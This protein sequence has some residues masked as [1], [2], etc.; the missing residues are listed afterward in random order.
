MGFFNR[1]LQEVSDRILYGFGSQEA[2]GRLMLAAATDEVRTQWGRYAGRNGIRR[3]TV[4]QFLEFAEF[5]YGFELS[6]DDEHRIFGSNI[7]VKTV[8]MDA[9][10]PRFANMLL[11][12]GVIDVS[13]GGEH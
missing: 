5:Q 2:A 8:D 6:E 7:D 13:L 9:M 11:E 12:Q 4:R 1:K 10:C 3:P